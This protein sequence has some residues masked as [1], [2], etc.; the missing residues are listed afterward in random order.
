MSGLEKT[1]KYLDSSMKK[2]HNQKLVCVSEYGWKKMTAVQAKEH[3]KKI[4]KGWDK[5]EEQAFAM[6]GGHHK[7]KNHGFIQQIRL[8]FGGAL[9]P[10]K[11]GYH[12]APAAEL[13]CLC[14]VQQKGSSALLWQ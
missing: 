5:D 4:V 6:M 8:S 10:W 14:R 9:V 2:G 1:K 11:H 13:D 7:D 3:G 12:Q